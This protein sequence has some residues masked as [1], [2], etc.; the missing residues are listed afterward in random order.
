MLICDAEY[1]C[2]LPLMFA[3]VKKVVRKFSRP[4]V[5]LGRSLLPWRLSLRVEASEP[6][7]CIAFEVVR[8]LSLA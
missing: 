8:D 4:Q 6:L 2:K 3:Q 1:D 5:D 7:Q